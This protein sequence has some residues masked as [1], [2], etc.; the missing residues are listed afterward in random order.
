M[1]CE[2][3]HL[4]PEDGVTVFLQNRD[5][6]TGRWRCLKHNQVTVNPIV[7]DFAAMLDKTIAEARK[8][9]N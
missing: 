4:G 2:V 7:L 1:V 5:G 8:K 6:E 3:C 9:L